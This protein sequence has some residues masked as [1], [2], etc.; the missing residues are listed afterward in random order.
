MCFGRAG[1][2]FAFFRFLRFSYF[3]SVFWVFQASSSSIGRRDTSGSGR[4]LHKVFSFLFRSSLIRRAG[5]HGGW[6]A[7]S[8]SFRQSF[9]PTIV[10]TPSPGIIST[11][12]FSQCLHAV[13]GST[14][15][16]GIPWFC[17]LVVPWRDL[18]SRF[19]VSI[20][21]LACQGKVASTCLLP[22]FPAYIQ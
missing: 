16:L 7:G 10:L 12:L 18:S 19:R 2:G 1:S 8:I 21:R 17:W 11:N 4:A 3:V 5:G 20:W 15:L 6:F 14:H 9:S 22:H 13:S